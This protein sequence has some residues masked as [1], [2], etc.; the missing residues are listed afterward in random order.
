MPSNDACLIGRSSG[1]LSNCAISF[2]ISEQWS[3]DMEDCS[4]ENYWL[5]IVENILLQLNLLEAM[6]EFKIRTYVK[7]DKPFLSSAHFLPSSM[8][9]CG[10]CL[11]APLQASKYL[12][13]HTRSVSFWRRL[14]PLLTSRCSS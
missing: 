3:M 1:F 4:S 13:A 10:S 8:G 11:K 2:V 7:I 6:H 9:W 12:L 14:Q 5:E